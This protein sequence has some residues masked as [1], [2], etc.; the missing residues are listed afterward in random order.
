[1]ADAKDSRVTARLTQTMSMV[2]NTDTTSARGQRQVAIGL[3][4]PEGLG[5]LKGFDFNNEALL[6]SVLLIDYSLDTTTGEITIP[7]F[8]PNQD[9]DQPGGATHVSFNS[10]FLNLDFGTGE[11]DFQ[12]STTVNLPINGTT[13]TISLTP[14]AAAVG[15]GNELFFLK[16]SFFQEVNGIQY[17]LRNG[18]FNALKLIEVL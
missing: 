8:T 12:S 11:K 13:S 7:D 9:L 2:K 3:T 18:A 1:M 4:T 16:V 6:S 17:P 15:T 14:S 10:G 5:R